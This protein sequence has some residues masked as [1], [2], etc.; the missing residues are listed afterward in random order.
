MNV[1]DF[2]APQD[3]A[4]IQSKSFAGIIRYVSDDT[5]KNITAPEFKGAMFRKLTVTLVCEQGNQPAMRGVSG[6]V[7]DVAVANKIADAVGYDKAAT[8]YY[9]AEDPNVLAMSAWPTVVSYFTAVNASSPRPVGGYGGRKLL[10]HLRSQGLVTKT[11]AVQTW[12]GS[13]PEDALEQLVGANTFGLSIDVDS[14][15]QADYGQHP[16]PTVVEYE[17]DS[18]FAVTTPPSTKHPQGLVLVYAMGAGSRAGQLLQFSRD[19]QDDTFND[20]I[21]ITDQIG[22]PDPYTVSA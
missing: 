22:G 12:G 20:V 7:H 5:L 21:D 17:E 4:V 16:R 3:L 13:S 10:D 18:M 14:V 9:V 6:G 2:S 11:W 8:I 15:L 1:C 19:P